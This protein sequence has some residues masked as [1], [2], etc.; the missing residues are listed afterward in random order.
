MQLSGLG[1]RG[2]VRDWAMRCRHAGQ[3]GGDC[4]HGDYDLLCVL[5]EKEELGMQV[6]E[7]V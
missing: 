7:R 6:I 4:A 2:G 1:Y 5:A 3:V